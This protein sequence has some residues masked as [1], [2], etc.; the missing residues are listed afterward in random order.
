MM[1]KL[2]FLFVVFLT[3]SGF[4]NTR[5]DNITVSWN[6]STS[7][8]AVGYD[9]YY[10]TNSGNYPYKINVGNTTTLTISNLSAGA[11]YYLAVT[12][13]D[14]NGNESVYSSEIS[15][16]VSGILTMTPGTSP[17]SLALIKF[18]VEPGH[19]YEVQAT[20]NLQSW[21]S[22]WQSGVIASNVWMQFTDPNARSFASRFYR[23][24]IH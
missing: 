15:N 16:V 22:I 2:Q 24:V 20:T 17:G 14:A 19:W 4:E 11:T 6:A 10:G 3:I 5:A 13:H 8:N 21:S 9:V 7:T 23:L 12:A 1:P 18:P